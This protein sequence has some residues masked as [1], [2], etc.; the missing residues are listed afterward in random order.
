MS[1]IY[2]VAGNPVFHSRSPG[3]FNAAF[4][5]LSLDAVYVRLAA[6]TAEEVLSTTREV[7][8]KGLN[9][10]SP[11][12]TDVIPFLD[13]VK[14]DAQRV[15]SV[16]TVIERDGR[17]I[18]YNTDVA[19]VVGALKESEFEP[20]GKK[21]VVVGAGGAGRA[22]ALALL[23]SGADVVLVNRTA[24]KAD[25]AARILGCDA[26]PLEH[27]GD[28][29]KGAHLL[30]SSISSN[31][32]VIEPSLLS[33]ELT[34]LE[35][36]YGRPTAL[37]R[38]ATDAGCRVIDGRLWLLHQALP[39]FTLFTEQGAPEKHMRK[40]LWKKRWA[41][42]RNIALIGFMGTGKSSV[43][44]EIAGLSGL[45]FID[46]DRAVEHKAGLPIAEIFDLKGEETFRM[47]EQAEL[48]ELWT[49]SHSVVSCGGG[50]VLSKRN[51]RVLRSTCVPVWLWAD[52][53]TALARIGET[54]TRPL[55]NGQSPESRAR[56][57]LQE[58]LFLYA[59]T[60]DLLINT[61]G[62]TPREIAARIWDEVHYAF[63]N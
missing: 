61:R 22:A 38:D 37:L 53:H 31:G 36:N 30:I 1:D 27:I 24:A 45:T 58:R 11:F 17:L 35:A 14:A 15:G 5:E 47:M 10:T 18:G 51:R 55:L 2:A 20:K 44:R 46:T 43:A 42:H 34:L 28:A 41:P 39:A 9:I 63:D 3:I 48:Q 23:S 4:K 54:D 13:E 25:E 29:L 60:S 32:R 6:S 49:L 8:I 26:L 33:K 57:L 52:V 40:A 50:A 21:A 16:N 62:K 59:C 12:K 19:G 56:A 7:G